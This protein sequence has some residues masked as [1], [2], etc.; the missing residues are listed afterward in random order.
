MAYTSG[1]A[2]I[3]LDINNLPNFTI[4][5]SEGSQHPVDTNFP[6]AK[7]FGSEE[8]AI[9]AGYEVCPEDADMQ[10]IDRKSTRLNS[11]HRAKSYASF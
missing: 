11:S 10:A 3:G 2:A 9:K 4:I 7:V 1:T 8:A 5:K 6:N